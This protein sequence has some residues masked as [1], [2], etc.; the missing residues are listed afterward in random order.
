[1]KTEPESLHIKGPG[2]KV[3]S[4]FKYIYSDAITLP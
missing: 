2:L 1:M 4:L 3:Y